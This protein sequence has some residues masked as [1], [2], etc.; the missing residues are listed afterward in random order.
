M[1][2]LHTQFKLQTSFHGVTTKQSISVCTGP[3]SAKDT[4]L[5]IVPSTE[6]TSSTSRQPTITIKMLFL[7]NYFKIYLK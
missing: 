7:C 1:L 2:M 4:R 5:K 3:S 6:S